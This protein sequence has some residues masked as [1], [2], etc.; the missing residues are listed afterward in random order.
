MNTGEPILVH[1]LD[2]TETMEPYIYCDICGLADTVLWYSQVD[3][4]YHFCHRHGA[5]QVRDFMTGRL[6]GYDD[7]QIY[8]L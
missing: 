1:Q 6:K 2:G 4:P 8:L 5:D 7:G 3:D